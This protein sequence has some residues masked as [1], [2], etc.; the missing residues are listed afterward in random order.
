MGTIRKNYSGLNQKDGRRS[1]ISSVLQEHQRQGVRFGGELREGV[2]EKEE[3]VYTTGV[4]FGGELREGVREKEE[5][6][7]TTGVR[8][9]G[10]LREGV[11]EKEEGVYTTG[12]RFGGEL[13]EGVREEE[14]GRVIRV[15]NI[16]VGGRRRPL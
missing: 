6:V 12:V 9:G 14:E 11:R 1:V 13:R 2:R 15:N 5:G 8:F 7:Y 4:R 10:E 16:P 3:G